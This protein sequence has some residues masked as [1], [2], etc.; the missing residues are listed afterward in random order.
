MTWTNFASLGV[1]PGTTPQLDAN[2]AALSALINVPCTVSGTN[3]LT[4][5]STAGTSTLVAYQNY[6][7]LD[8]VAAATNNGPVTANFNGIGPMNVYKDTPQGPQGLTGGEIVQNCGFALIYDSALNSSAGGFHLTG[9]G[10]PLT[11]QSITVASLNATVASVAS[12]QVGAS[13]VNAV[14]RMYSTLAS[15]SFG[16]IVPGASAQ[17]TVSFAGCQVLDNVIV[18]LPAAPQASVSYLGFVSAAGSIVMRASNNA[19]GV[20]VTVSLTTFESPT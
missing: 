11:G 8:G 9:G 6:M 17:S 16:A 12:I 14:T 4:L 3:T 10:A 15:I 18:G 7:N 13:V 5:T 19:V 1:G 20:T 2:F